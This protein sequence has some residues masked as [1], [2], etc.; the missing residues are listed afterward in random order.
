MSGEFLSSDGPYPRFCQVLLPVRTITLSGLL[1][2]EGGTPV[3]RL[4][5][6]PHGVCP[7]ARVTWCAVRSYRTFSP[8]PEGGLFSVAL[9]VRTDFGPYGLSFRIARFPVESGSS[10]QDC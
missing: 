1:G 9:S 5:L 7:A 10:S 6:A 3:D 8:L 4:G 2:H